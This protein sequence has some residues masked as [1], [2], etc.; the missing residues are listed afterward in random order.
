MVLNV[1]CVVCSLLFCWGFFVGILFCFVCLF[2]W[3]FLFFFICG[4]FVCGFCCSCVVLD[5]SYFVVS[6]FFLSS[7]LP[8]LF[9][10]LFIYLVVV[11][12]CFCYV[13]IAFCG[14]ISFL[15]Y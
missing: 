11:G 2:L 1:V 15:L 9:I 14:V 7:F 5:F 4:F 13:A 3:F 8:F 6:F 12:F 10:Y